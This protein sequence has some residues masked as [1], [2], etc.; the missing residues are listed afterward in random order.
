MRENA[1]EGV[2]TTTRHFSDVRWR[3]SR[4]EFVANVG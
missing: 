4:S 3:L 1:E 2:T